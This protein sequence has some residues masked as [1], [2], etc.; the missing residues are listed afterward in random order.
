[1]TLLRAA[2]N[3]ELDPIPNIVGHFGDHITIV[4]S[5]SLIFVLQF[6]P[7]D[8][9]IYT[10]QLWFQ[11]VPVPADIGGVDDMTAPQMVVWI[12]QMMQVKLLIFK[13]K[14]FF[15]RWYYL[16]VVLVTGVVVYQELYK[17]D[18]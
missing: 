7:F 12:A 16:I 15:W 14:N 3:L 17:Y 1:M 10:T 6:Q 9:N 8:F 11:H 5:K 13:L 2:N 4:Q 18:S